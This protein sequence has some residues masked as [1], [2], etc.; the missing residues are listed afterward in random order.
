MIK[1]LISV[2]IPVVICAMA[3]GCSDDS[4][5][6]VCNPGVMMDCNCAG[7]GEGARTCTAAYPLAQQDVIHKAAPI[8]DA[9]VAAKDKSDPYLVFAHQVAQSRHGTQVQ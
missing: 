1:Q 4:V 7:G 6:T 8:G 2:W 5:A 9:E 3:W